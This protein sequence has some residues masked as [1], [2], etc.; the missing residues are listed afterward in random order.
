MT[1]FTTDT[2]I[3]LNDLEQSIALPTASAF[4]VPKGR[5]KGSLNMNGASAGIMMR[6]DTAAPQTAHSD[7]AGDSSLLVLRRTQSGLDKQCAVVDRVLPG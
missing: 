7:P 2:H 3:D 6:R 1:I 4:S 5:K